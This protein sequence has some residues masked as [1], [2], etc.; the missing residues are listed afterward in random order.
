MV[1]QGTIVSGG[2]V[3][4]SILGP[5]VR[6]NSFAQVSDSILF[7]GVSVGR[8]SKLHKTIIDKHV[9]IPE[10]VQIGYDHEMDRAR[11][12]SVTERGVVIVAKSDDPSVWAS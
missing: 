3:R 7:E 1:C 8:H 5:S 6:V 10:G 12:F 11:G 2:T 9:Q 4:R